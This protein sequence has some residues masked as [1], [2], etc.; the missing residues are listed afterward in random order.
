MNEVFAWPEG[1]L[2]LY[3]GSH[4]ASGSV[5]AYV[6]NIN[7]GI[8]VAWQSDP[9]VDGTYRAHYTDQR[10]DYSFSVDWAYGETLYTLFNAQTAVHLKMQANMA[11]IGSAGLFIYSGVMPS[12]NYAGADLGV[13]NQTVNGFGHSWSAF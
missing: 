4:T 6:R 9:A 3:T 13:F 1:D 5:I 7:V 8:N 12:F 11:T 2:Y 10:A